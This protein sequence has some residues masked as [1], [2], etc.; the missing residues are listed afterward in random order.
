MAQLFT[1][2][3]FEA[4]TVYPKLH[5]QRETAGPRLMQFWLQPPFKLA[6][7]LIAEQDLPSELIRYPE[8]HVQKEIPGP[9]LIQ[10]CRHPPLPD[11]QLLMGI[12]IDPEVVYPAL[13]MQW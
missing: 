1:A 4:D 11:A 2:M 7:L 13:Q 5:V 3:Q 9:V 10:L 6:Q 8:L 12:H